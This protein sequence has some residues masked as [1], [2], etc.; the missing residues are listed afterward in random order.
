MRVF[1]GLSELEVS[2]EMGQSSVVTIGNFDGV[3]RGH[4]ALLRRAVERAKEL[5]VPSV[6]F[7]FDPHPL[8]VLRPELKLKLLFD[9]DDRSE[10][11][12]KLGIDVLVIEPFSRAFSQLTP[13]RFVMDILV[14]PFQPKAVLVGYDFSFGSNRS[15]SIE[16][17]KSQAKPMGFELEVLSPVTIE[18]DGHPTIVSSSRIRHALERGEAKA[19]RVL[20]GRPY[21]LRGIVR[22]GAGRG[23]TIGIPTA[24]LETTVEPGIQKGVYAAFACFRGSRFHAM[25]NIG[26]NPTFTDDVKLHVEAH[27]PNLEE[28]LKRSAGAEGGK[29]F[30]TDLYGERVE[31]QFIDRI[32]DEKKFSGVDALVAQIRSDIKT[33]LEI[34]ERENP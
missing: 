26:N 2:A 5:G 17:L 14:K 13:E 10:Q 9:P 16:F 18:L 33:G 4:Q 8:M 25:V 20:L 7:T 24:N 12:Q 31:L 28:Q 6:V 21:A 1:R 22:K 23:R 3:H 11:M 34:L 30:G 29:S 19:A 15:G 32:R 27:I